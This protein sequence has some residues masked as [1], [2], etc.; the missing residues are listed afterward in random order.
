MTLLG[1]IQTFPESATDT[2]L[3]Q[4]WHHI[5]PGYGDEQADAGRDCRIRLAGPFSGANGDRDILI[6][7]FS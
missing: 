4:Q 3:Y 6:S 2:L 1:H 7:L 5:Q